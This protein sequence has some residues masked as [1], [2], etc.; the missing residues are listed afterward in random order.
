MISELIQYANDHFLADVQTCDRKVTQNAE[1][2]LSRARL[3]ASYTKSLKECLRFLIGKLLRKGSVMF[4][5]PVAT[6][7]YAATHI[8][9]MPQAANETLQEN[10]QRFTYLLIQTTVTNPTTAVFQVTIILFIRHLFNKE[11]KMQVAR[12][13]AIQILRYGITLAG[14]AEI[15]LKKCPG[16]NSNDPLVLHI[17]L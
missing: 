12:A 10:I 17:H 15:K 14:E 6:K 9:S 11:I 16:L 1:L 13:K 7:M 8:H 2:Q 3:K 5:S 4:F